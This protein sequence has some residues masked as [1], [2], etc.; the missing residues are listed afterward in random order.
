[1]GFPLGTFPTQVE[2][3]GEWVVE[4][5]ASE[6]YTAIMASSNKKTKWN[7]SESDSENEVADFLRFIV[8][9]SLEEVWLTKFSAFLIEKAISTRATLKTVK[10]RNSNLLV[11]VNSQRQVESILNINCR[12]YPHEKLNTSKGVI[13]NMVVTLATKE[14]I[15]SALGKQ[16]VTNIRIVFFRKGEERIQTNT[17]IQTFNQ[18]HTPKEMK[19]GC[20]LESQAVCPSTPEVLQMPKIW[21]PLGS[22]KRTTRV[23]NAV[24]ETQITWSKLDVQTADKIIWLM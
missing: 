16:G 17:Y 9:E 1:M 7:L 14:E 6:K 19:I 3:N 5:R 18:P 20:C 10:T 11:E 24:K 15:A 12:A 13:W 21:T 22:L 8:I 4:H 2:L 23:P